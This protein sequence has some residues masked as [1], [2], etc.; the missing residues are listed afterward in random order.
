MPDQVRQWKQNLKEIERT[1]ESKFKSV[2]D[3]MGGTDYSK[4]TCKQFVHDFCK[5]AQ[6]MLETKFGAWLQ[7]ALGIAALLKDDA[8]SVYG[9]C[10]D[11][12][13][14]HGMGAPDGVPANLWS[15]IHTMV[16]EAADE[17]AEVHVTLSGGR[18]VDL[19]TYLEARY[20]SVCVHNADSER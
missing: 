6:A 5:T 20:M 7:P 10:A 3:A 16:E 1:W 11:L 19:Q 4:E 9:K 13:N 14:K 17:L 18:T 2:Y 8:T 12:V 15:A